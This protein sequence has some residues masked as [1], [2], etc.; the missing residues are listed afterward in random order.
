MKRTIFLTTIIFIIGVLSACNKAPIIPAISPTPI[1]NGVT[2]SPNAT[3][4]PAPA[5][6]SSTSTP[7]IEYKSVVNPNQPY[8][9][10]TMLEDCQ[11]LKAMYGDLIQLDSIG[12]SVEGRDLVLI[13]FGKGEKKIVLAGT[14]HAREYITSSFLM[15]TVD[16][17]ACAYATTGDFNGYDVKKLLDSVTLYIVPMVNPDGVNLVL[18]GVDSTKDPAKV[19][20]M[21]MLQNSYSEWKA[22]INGVDLNR[23]YPCYWDI[24]ATNTNVPSSE[25][26]KG[27]A[28]A[29]EP[30]VQALMRLCQ[31]NNFLLA[32][33]FHSKGEV[34]YWADSGTNDAIQASNSMAESIA[35]A[36]GYK[37]MSVTQ[38]P[39]TYG[40]GFEN[41]F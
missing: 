27:T 3:Q 7:E 8:S 36:T 23:Q 2:H 34:I 13:K 41:W 5:T 20:N 37:L 30:E 21:R 15:E 18:N 33:S 17:Y 40:A 39:A 12:K 38:D 25:M 1:G 29:T 28:P 16:E 10:E 35:Q 31:E 6:Q 11:A 14:H 19:R 22:N 26:Y 32:A 4:S 9:Y 24:K